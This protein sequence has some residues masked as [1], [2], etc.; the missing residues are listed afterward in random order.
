MCNRKFRR[1]ER[2]NISMGK[3]EHLPHQQ[4]E[5]MDPWDL[6]GDGKFYYHANKTDGW[7]VKMMR[8]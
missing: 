4:I 1:R 8:K 7:Y 5:V 2:Q 6:G 3:Y